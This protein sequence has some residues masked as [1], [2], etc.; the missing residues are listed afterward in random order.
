MNLMDLL[1]ILLAHEACRLLYQNGTPSEYELISR[2]KQIF[3]SKKLVIARVSMNG[4]KKFQ[5]VK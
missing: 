3:F 5:W 1:L 4:S 2:R